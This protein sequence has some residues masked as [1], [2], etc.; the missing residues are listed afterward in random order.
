MASARSVS[1]ERSWGKGRSCDANRAADS[2]RFTLTQPAQ[3]RV[4]F[5]VPYLGYALAAL[6]VRL[7]RMLVIGL[8]ALVIG[9]AFAVHLWRAPDPAEP[10]AA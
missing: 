5:D 3:A 2:W 6:G 4:A 7:V 1:S 9:L 10:V 8:P